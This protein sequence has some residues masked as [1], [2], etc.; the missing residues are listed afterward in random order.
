MSIYTMILEYKGGSYVT[1]IISNNEVAAMQGW[2]EQLRFGSV[3]DD[4]ADEV[5]DAFEANPEFDPTPITGLKNVWCE[6]ATSHQELA[7]VTIIAT[8]T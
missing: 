1:Q 4:V 3:A 5:A 7:L 8:A 2:V 6:A